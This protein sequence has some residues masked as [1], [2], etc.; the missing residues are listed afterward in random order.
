MQVVLWRRWQSTIFCYFT[1]R[2]FRHRPCGSS[3]GLPRHTAEVP[4]L[5]IKCALCNYKVFGPVALLG[6]SCHVRKSTHFRD[7]QFWLTTKEQNKRKKSTAQPGMS[8]R[9]SGEHVRHLPI[10][11]AGLGFFCS[12][13]RTRL[14]AAQSSFSASPAPGRADTLWFF[15]AL[16]Q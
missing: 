4:M 16:N 14:L 9:I 2:E 11:V 12:V 5:N 6:K 1:C 10:K 13:R 3:C 8:F 15:I 7:T